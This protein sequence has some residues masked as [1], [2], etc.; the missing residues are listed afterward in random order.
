MHPHFNFFMT[1]K[2]EFMVASAVITFILY[3]PFSLHKSQHLKS[4]HTHF[5]FFMTIKFEFVV[6]SAVE[7]FIFYLSFSLHKT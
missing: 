2:F 5:N 4:M 7:T 1:I 3:L 6:S